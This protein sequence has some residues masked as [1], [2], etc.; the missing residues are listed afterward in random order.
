MTKKEKQIYKT[1]FTHHLDMYNNWVIK[2]SAYPKSHKDHK[3]Y[4]SWACEESEALNTIAYL[5]SLIEKIPYGEAYR[6]LGE[7]K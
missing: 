7:S 6:I 3:R 4:V 1:Q 5:Y 2:A